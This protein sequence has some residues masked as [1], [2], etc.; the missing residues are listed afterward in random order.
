MIDMPKY[1]IEVSCN[2]RKQTTNLVKI[3]PVS[4][5]VLTFYTDSWVNNDRVYQLRGEAKQRDN[6]QWWI[7]YFQMYRNLPFDRLPAVSAVHKR[8]I[9]AVGEA[10]SR[11][12]D[13]NESA[14]ESINNIVYQNRRASILARMEK[15]ESELSDLRL[16][17]VQLD[18]LDTTEL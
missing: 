10:F 9:N 1:T 15:L 3:I 2:D 16:E 8:A 5:K 18:N 6:G 7:E 4:S 11:W 13:S 17:L 14:L 12:I